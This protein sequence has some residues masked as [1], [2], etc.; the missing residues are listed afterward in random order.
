MSMMNKKGFDMEKPEPIC[1][2]YL[3]LLPYPQTCQ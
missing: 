1:V 2:G 3:G